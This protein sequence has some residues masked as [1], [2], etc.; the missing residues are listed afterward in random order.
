MASRTNPKVFYAGT[1]D[2]LYKTYDAGL[3]WYRVR[4]YTDAGLDAL[5]LGLD[6]EPVTIKQVAALTEFWSGGPTTIAGEHGLNFRIPN[7]EVATEVTQEMRTGNGI[8]KGLSWVIDESVPNPPE[9]EEP[10]F[11]TLAY[12]DTAWAEISFTWGGYTFEALGRAWTMS[13][14]R[15]GDHVMDNDMYMLYRHVF[16]PETP[17]Q[18]YLRVLLTVVGRKQI[19]K[20]WFNGTQIYGAGAAARPIA[21][22]SRGIPYTQ[23]EI[24]GAYRIDVTDLILPGEPNIIA[25]YT[26]SRHIGIAPGFLAYRLALNTADTLSISTA[27]PGYVFATTSEESYTMDLFNDANFAAWPHGHTGIVYLDDPPAGWTNQTFDDSGWYFGVSPARVT[28]GQASSIDPDELIISLLHGSQWLN[29]TWDTPGPGGGGFG[30]AIRQ[31]WAV[32][33]GIYTTATVS[34]RWSHKIRMWLNGTLIH[35]DE[36]DF[37]P[38]VP[39]SSANKGMLHE[40]LAIDVLSA[41]KPGEDNVLCIQVWRDDIYPKAWA[42]GD[43]TGACAIMEVT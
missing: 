28:I 6:S 17:A 22:I 38:T 16:T 41:L 31:H 42:F 33:D 13:P 23:A 24:D 26:I 39:V 1:T 36:S 25:G 11:W 15:L 34:V 10:N 20:L 2:G 14:V 19:V 40:Q 27:G 21:T 9:G 3:S 32:P 18:P 29:V 35:Q 8:P 7:A 4:S 37:I 30:S 12:D 43:F 5:Q